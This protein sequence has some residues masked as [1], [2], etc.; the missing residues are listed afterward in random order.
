MV[1]IVLYPIKIN[2]QTSNIFSIE[3][4][5][6]L[7]LEYSKKQLKKETDKKTHILSELIYENGATWDTLPI[8]LRARGNFRRGNC[9]FPPI[10]MYFEKGSKKRSLFKG[11]KNVKL[12]LPCLLENRSNDDVLKEYLAYKFYEI[13]SDIHF[14]TRLA[15]IEYI[16]TRGQKAELHPLAAFMPKPSL[17]EINDYGGEIAFASRKPKT[18]TILAIIIEDDKVVAKRHGAKILKRVVHPLTKKKQA[19]LP[20]P[21]FNT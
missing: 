8:T 15:S 13:L 1:F 10:K 7:K 17:E 2:S 4:P 12:V 16:D 9:F 20:M 21:Y 3:I 14:N 18:Y 11:H 19:L 5:I 6:S